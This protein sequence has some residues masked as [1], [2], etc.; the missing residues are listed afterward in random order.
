VC[1]CAC[2]RACVWGGGCVR[3]SVRACVLSIR[4][5]WWIVCNQAV[6]TRRERKRE[7]GRRVTGRERMGRKEGEKTEGEKPREKGGTETERKGQG[8][9][10][11]R[12]RRWGGEG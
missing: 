12:W 1:V 10:G 7:K 11:G 3:A 2:V 5:E 4:L 9:G 6:K 8:V